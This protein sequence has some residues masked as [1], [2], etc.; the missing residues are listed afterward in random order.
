MNN[1]ILLI[2]CTFSVG[3]VSCKSH[4][5]A[6]VSATARS[7]SNAQVQTINSGEEAPQ[8]SQPQPI[9]TPIASSSPEPD[10]VFSL[11]ATGSSQSAEYRL[12]VDTTELR[13]GT[14]T[15]SLCHST[16]FE[17]LRDLE[18]QEHLPDSICPKILR[19]LTSEVVVIPDLLPNKI[20]FVAGIFKRRDAVFPIPPIEI[21]TIPS[22]APSISL[23]TGLPNNSKS[24]LGF[25]ISAG[26]TRV[27][28]CTVYGSTLSAT[29]RGICGKEEGTDKIT[30]LG[31]RPYSQISFSTENVVMGNVAIFNDFTNK[32]LWRTDGTSAGTYPLT[33]LSSLFSSIGHYTAPGYHQSAVVGSKYFFSVTYT[34]NKRRVWVTDG[35]VAGTNLA[36]DIDPAYSTQVDNL[37]EFNGDLYFTASDAANGNELWKYHPGDPAASRLT[38]LRSGAGSSSPRALMRLGTKLYFFAAPDTT[39]TRLYSVDTAGTVTMVYNFAANGSVAELGIASGYFVF[40]WGGATTGSEPWVSDGTTGGTT[41]LKDIF[42]GISGS[43]PI[44]DWY[45]TAIAPE[46]S[47]SFFTAVDDVNGRELW[48]TDGTP[49]GTT[50]VYSFRQ[51]A[52]VSPGID[53]TVSYQMRIGNTVYVSAKNDATGIELYRIEPGPVVSALTEQLAPGPTSSSPWLGWVEGNDPV[54]R[55]SQPTI[56]EEYWKLNISNLI[57]SPTSYGN[58]DAPQRTALVKED[59]ILFPVIKS[60]S[61]SSFWTSD[62]TVSGTLDTDWTLHPGHASNSYLGAVTW[63]KNIDG[64]MRNGNAVAIVGDRFLYSEYNTTTSKMNVYS[65]D[66]TAAG[67]IEKLAD[68]SL[69]FPVVT[70]GLFG[71]FL[72]EYSLSTGKRT[73]YSLNPVTADFTQLSAPWATYQSIS[74]PTTYQLGQTPDKLVFSSWASIGTGTEIYA[75]DG[76]SVSQLTDCPGAA[77]AHPPGAESMSALGKVFFDGSNCVNDYELWVTDGTAPGTVLVKDINASGPSYPREFTVVDGLLYFTADDGVNGRRVWVTDGTSGGTAP[78]SFSGPVMSEPQGLTSLESVLYFMADDGVHGSEV[79]KYTPGPQSSAQQLLDYSEGPGSSI[80][81]SS[82]ILNGELLISVAGA[83]RISA[84]FFLNNG[85][86]PR[87]VPET[88]NGPVTILGAGK[89][90]VWLE[91]GTLHSTGNELRFVAWN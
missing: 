82:K 24:F 86:A 65:T 7:K 63:K 42:P 17:D 54:V 46:H 50:I 3:L 91:V 35:T 53:P 47:L 9:L 4:L 64:N 52:G 21:E 19:D 75:W 87:K 18:K 16:N 38:D 12:A 40:A 48:Q 22:L 41:L 83:N 69:R 70:E 27:S 67:T 10:P 5:N 78:I 59:K 71:N 20:Y 33:P 6:S 57:W 77:S 8:A 56:G 2:G 1:L 15:F 36:F 58:P 45:N 39:T 23:R 11:A 84:L 73:I 62:G 14:A 31:G 85:K 28:D 72:F 74:G 30:F 81:T 32:Q 80:L 90:G 61:L 88:F 79:W 26:A 34:D 51:A 43:S 49:A 89:K 44:T 68:L 76:A 13:A 29:K 25:R 66:G 37:T 60:G 55:I